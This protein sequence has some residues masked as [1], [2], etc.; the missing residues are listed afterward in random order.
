MWQDCLRGKR[1]EPDWIRV[2]GNLTP[3]PPLEG[4]TPN[5]AMPGAITGA[6]QAASKGP[7]VTGIPKI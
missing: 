3:A 1:R 7:E 4:P 2:A 6:Q 5:V